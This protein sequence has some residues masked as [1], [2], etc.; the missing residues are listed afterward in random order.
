MDVGRVVV[1]ELDAAV[2]G[3]GAVQQIGAGP[4]AVSMLCDLFVDP[5][6]HGRGCG[7]AMLADLWSDGWPPDDVQQPAR[8]CA[9]AVHELRPGRLVAAAV[10]AR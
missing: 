5:G 9:P 2:A 10:P 7:R 4:D 8:E 1:A 3:F 6:A